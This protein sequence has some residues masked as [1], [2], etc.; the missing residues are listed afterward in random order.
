MESNQHLLS[1]SRRDFNP[2]SRVVWPHFSLMM[3]RA[4]GGPRECALP[5]DVRVSLCLFSQTAGLPRGTRADRPP[6]RPLALVMV[7]ED[8]RERVEGKDRNQ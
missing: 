3:P 5:G 1:S 4:S 8:W 6:A 7:V 2:L